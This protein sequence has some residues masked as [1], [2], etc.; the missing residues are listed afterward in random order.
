MLVVGNGFSIYEVD[1]VI[2]DKLLGEER[3]SVN[4]IVD[5][6]GLDELDRVIVLISGDD[7]VNVSV[8]FDGEL[9]DIKLVMVMM[10]EEGALEDIEIVMM[11]D[12]GELVR[13]VTVR[14]LVRVSVKVWY[15]TGSDEE[16][17]CVTGD[18]TELG[19]GSC[20]DGPTGV[21]VEVKGTWDSVGTV[22]IKVITD[23]EGTDDDQEEISVGELTGWVSEGLVY[24]SGV[25]LPDDGVPGL[26]VLLLGDDGLADVPWLVIGVVD[27]LETLV[28]GC[29]TEV[30]V[31]GTGGEK[32]LLGVPGF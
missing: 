7:M 1:E 2:V 30:R 8:L 21:G 6:L 15:E 31:E 16:W 29:D 26:A 9:E 22:G 10:L 14:V 17:D 32:L 13:S 20:D 12:E 28:D 23:D 18:T 4:I 11:L 5:L 27:V 19:G 3:V 24:V 25:P